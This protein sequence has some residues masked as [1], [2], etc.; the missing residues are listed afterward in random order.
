MLISLSGKWSLC[1]GQHTIEGHVPGDVT[2]DV[3]LAGLIGEPY[4]GDNCKEC[5][6]VTERDW[7]YEREFV[8]DVLPPAEENTYL[9]FKGVDTYADVL[10]NG[11]LLGKTESMQRAYEFPVRDALRQG[12]NLLTVRL[13][14]VFDKIGREEQKKYGSIFHANRIFARKAQ[15]HFGW[16]WAPRFPGYGIFRDVELVSEPACALKEVNIRPYV[17][18]DATFRLLFGQKF[19]GEVSI[20][21]SR[22]GK[23]AARFESRVNCKKLICNL[24][25]E[26]PSLWWPNGY[27]EQTLYD[28]EIV[29]TQNGVPV[30]TKKGYFGFREVELDKRVLDD[31]TLDFAFKINGRPVYCRGSNWVPAECMTGRLTDDKYYALLKAAKDANINMLRVWGGGIYESDCFYES[32]DRLGIMLWHDFM[33][34]CSEIPEDNADFMRVLTEETVQQVKRLKNHPCLTYWCGMNEPTGSFSEA[35]GKYS[36]FTLH[37][38]FRGIVGEYSEEIPYGYS[39][40]YA[41]ADVEN[42]SSEGDIHANVTELDL[43]NASF[44]GFEKFEYDERN[45]FSAARICNYDEYLTE[46]VGNF[47]SECAVLGA[48]NYAS[49][50]KFTPETCRNLQSD[51][52]T[53]RFLGNP[54]TYVMPT[55]YERQTVLATAM[56]GAPENLKDFLKKVNKTQLDIMRSE[57]VYARSNKRSHGMLTWMFNDTW[58]T[59]TWSVVDYYLSKKPAYYAMK[60]CFAPLLAEIIKIKGRYYLCVANDTAEPF[61]SEFDVAFCDYGGKPVQ[62]KCVSVALGVGEREQIEI[63][64]GDAG[65]YIRFGYTL[66]GEDREGICWAGCYEKKAYAPDYAVETKETPEGVLVAV[67]AKTFV[68]CFAVFAPEHATLSDNFVDIPAGSRKEI[69]AYGAKE[70]EIAYASFCE[71]WN[72]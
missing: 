64:A 14:N 54:Y 17:S 67:N 72:R 29:Q 21:L 30:D 34:A 32:C 25:V 41:F 38:L 19:E 69:M 47:T 44:K 10:L 60:R 36:F 48:C 11:V 59:G 35:E 7:T 66:N 20:V 15:C 26:D 51:F 37:Y 43:F 62:K 23:E 42:N 24:H 58:P 53:K 27:G 61:H 57:I 50:L 4:Y 56:Y 46:S 68:P 45:T 16:D 8:L 2:N 1:D 71:E 40:P 52:F 55:F 31:R 18:G 9:R 70:R 6:W 13:Y 3:Y 5:L 28:Y 49:I 63:G 33:F 65:G 22:K 12:S 39:S